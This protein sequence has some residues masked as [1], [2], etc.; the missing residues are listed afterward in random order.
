MDEFHGILL[1]FLAGAIIFFF[2]QHMVIQ[3]YQIENQLLKDQLDR[4]NNPA[5]VIF[6][7]NTIHDEF[8]ATF[9]DDIKG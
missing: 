3:D 7:S 8:L 6:S 5:E 1:L 2:L 9:K 4:K